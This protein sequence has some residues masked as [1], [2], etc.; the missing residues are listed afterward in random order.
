MRAAIA[1]QSDCTARTV[2]VGAADVADQAPRAGKDLPHPLQGESSSEET[3]SRAPSR[4]PG[5]V[6]S[7]SWVAPGVWP[8]ARGCARRCDDSRRVGALSRRRPVGPATGAEAGA[9][10]AINAPRGGGGAAGVQRAAA[11]LLQVTQCCGGMPELAL[12]S[13]WRRRVLC[14]P[15]TSYDARSVDRQPQAAFGTSAASSYGSSMRGCPKPKT[16]TNPRQA[17]GWPGLRR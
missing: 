14:A 8:G 6:I 7:R 16:I 2:Y 11:A 5:R 1:H 4:Y 10:R 9:T 12:S 15:R 3:A 17:S 13:H